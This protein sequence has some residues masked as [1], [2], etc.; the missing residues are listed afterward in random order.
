M[1]KTALYFETGQRKQDGNILMTL[2]LVIFLASLLRLYNLGGRSL[3]YDEAASVRNV[4]G[5]LKLYPY[6]DWGLFD[7]LKRER[8]PPLYFF[9]MIPFY[10]FSS[11][12]W[13]IRLASVIFGIATIPLM[14]YFGSRLFN[15]KIGFIGALL[16]T[17]S[18]LHI[19]YSQE[20]R[21]Y[22]LFL[23]FS[24]LVFYLSYLALEDKKTLTTLD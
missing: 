21:P 6:E 14:Y 7:L 16:L 12:E 23:F 8:V 13:S 17:F 5:L 18:P 9:Y 1:Q 22:S 24:V 10:Y 19:Y 15:R 3:W 11:S 2:I 20:L 4:M